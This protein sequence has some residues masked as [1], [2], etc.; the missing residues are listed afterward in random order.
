M[1]FL[2]VLAVIAMAF[3]AFAVIAPAET[4]DAADQGSLAFGGDISIGTYTIG[5]QTTVCN[6]TGT[7]PSVTYLGN[8]ITVSYAAATA[9][10]VETY[11]V[12]G[13]LKNIDLTTGSTLG[14][15]VY[16][17]VLVFK[18]VS[19]TGTNH[20]YTKVGS[21]SWN[22]K[23]AVSS[24]GDWFVLGV[25][26]ERITAGAYYVYE[27]TAAPTD[28]TSAGVIKVDTSGLSIAQKVSTKAEFVA[29]INDSKVNA[30]IVTADI[31][32]TD[33][34]STTKPISFKGT[35]AITGAAGE[36]ITATFYA[37]EQ[38]IDL[39]GVYGTVRPIKVGNNSGL[40][41]NMGPNNNT[42]WQNDVVGTIEMTSGAK[43]TYGDGLKTLF[44]TS[45]TVAVLTAGK[46]KTVE[47]GP[48][49]PIAYTF[50]DATM[51][52]QVTENGT[53]L[54]FKA[55]DTITLAKTT[56]EAESYV[57]TV[58]GTLVIPAGCT[59][60]NN[61]T[62]KSHATAATLTNNG[63][64]VNNGTISTSN[65][66]FAV[67]SKLGEIV[68]EIPSPFGEVEKTSVVPSSAA[69]ISDDKILDINGSSAGT[70]DSPVPKQTINNTKTY[71]IANGTYFGDVD[72]TAAETSGGLQIAGAT[73]TGTVTGKSS[74]SA[75]LSGVKGNLLLGA[76]SVKIN[77]VVET[78]TIVITGNATIT[79]DS[80]LE[81]GSKI[82]LNE[83]AV[84]TI[85]D[86]F[87]LTVEAG[88][89]IDGYGKLVVGN[90]GAAYLIIEDGANVLCDVEYHTAAVAIGGA[91][92]AT[93][94]NAAIQQSN[95]IYLSANAT[96]A[97]GVT[98]VIPEGV[99]FYLN[100]HNLTVNAG[101]ELDITR[102]TVYM[103]TDASNA[104]M[105]DAKGDDGRIVMNG[106]LYLVSASVYAPVIVS[107]T[108]GYT[109][110]IGATEM[111]VLRGTEN[112]QVA[113]GNTI[114]LNNIT[115]DINKTI[116]VF[117]TLKLTGTNTISNGGALNIYGNAVASVE[118]VAS[119]RIH[120]GTATVYG[121][122]S[123]E[124]T[125]T[126]T[127]DNGGAVF[128]VAGGYV[129]T[130]GTF[131]VIKA[132]S[133]D[134]V[135]TNDLFV[136]N[137]TFTN[138]G[139]LTITG[140]QKGV[141][142]NNG[143]M[144]FNGTSGSSLATAAS[145]MLYDGKSVQVTSVTG[146]DLTI[147]DH[148]NIC[149]SDLYTN[150]GDAKENVAYSFGNEIVLNNVKGVLVSETVKVSVKKIT[151]NAGTDSKNI[152]FFVGNMTVAQT[153][154]AVS[155]INDAVGG[156]LTVNANAVNYIP[157]ETTR[158]AYTYPSYGFDGAI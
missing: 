73:Y 109:S 86:G 14:M 118:G 13:T 91:L 24:V 71:T 135:K 59:L 130:S 21:G 58:S 83:G 119:Q 66:D 134:A 136:Q 70:A 41:F 65:N 128:K 22:D 126:V 97:N 151:N 2:A 74:S 85:D 80:I 64:I 101:A 84:L 4:D 1:K 51:T 11:T 43:Y 72:V 152:K 137:G 144:V 121:T 45:G 15:G 120:Q 63:K 124:G 42:D 95:V 52:F 104:A 154:T 82:I 40:Y 9:G 133:P 23:G 27:G 62:F 149:Y 75:L 87:K 113:Y 102:A 99:I 46:M 18:K 67:G 38:Y 132:R 61:V 69:T 81:A 146:Q 56:G 77:G 53:G 29:A 35:V 107:P 106:N 111:E 93:V 115:M 3:A 50:T 92:T 30:I 108:T 148:R 48:G 25:T 157:N 47:A 5:G 16:N 78:G 156:S 131:N 60:T 153:G 139:A 125:V 145:I 100:G 20:I 140:T 94:V 127:N 8:S 37:G 17:N 39:K 98:I 89:T 44:G 150:N 90:T 129:T 88:A 147:Y 12:T 142:G 116:D 123:N 155:A 55:G 79:A 6:G 110:I 7:T 31:T 76:G 19:T 68:G 114:I 143:T 33:A 36:A 122:F 138:M 26:A 105:V 10:S 103:G 57:A 112:V 32:L 49:E 28:V 96:I 34:V 54:Y 141:V 158:D 117:G